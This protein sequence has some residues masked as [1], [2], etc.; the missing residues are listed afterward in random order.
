MAESSTLKKRYKFAPGTQREF[1]NTALEELG[2]SN[3]EAAKKLSVSTRS[4]TDW[5]RE[6]FSIPISAVKIFSKISGVK[7]PKNRKELD[8]FW[9]VSK[10]ARK[11]GLTSFKKQ[12]GTIGNP[13]LRKQRWY[14]WWEK[15]GKF[16]KRAI[17]QRKSIAKPH[18]SGNLAEFVG[19]MLGDGGISNGQVTVT[20]NRET[21]RDY[22]SYVMTLEKELFGVKPSL[23][24]DKSSLAVALVVSRVE[25]VDFCKE[26]GLKVGNKIKQGADIPNWVKANRNFIKLCVRGLIDTD[27]SF[28]THKYMSRGKLYQYK[29]IDFS[30]CSRPLLNSVFI[31]LKDLGLR[32]RIVR[33]GKKLRIESI[34][35]VKRYVE[36]IGTSNPKHLKR[37]QK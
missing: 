35:T 23:I 6:K 1:I 29:K 4:I 3:E 36:V 12:G 15:E 34:D 8:E 28:F 31:F 7:I 11:G 14:E 5:K 32:P 21:D 18:K 26:I 16:Q 37:Y 22:V 10:G 13:E 20:L 24:K 25:L 2:W 19:I 30:S 9:Y 17:F 27:G 33:D